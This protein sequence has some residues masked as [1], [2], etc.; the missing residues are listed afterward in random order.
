MIVESKEDE[1]VRPELIPK[2]CFFCHSDI[3]YPT[4]QWSGDS[5]IGF[6]PNC[7]IDFV[8]RIMRD[9]HQIEQ[10]QNLKVS[11]H[12]KIGIQI[13]GKTIDRIDCNTQVTE[14]ELKRVVLSLKSVQELI[15]NKSIKKIVIVPHRLVNILVEEKDS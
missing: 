15:Q 9:V 10:R 4:I 6:H 3:T 1:D 8:I 14:D 13:E 7:A 11:F 2:I 12:N 5:V